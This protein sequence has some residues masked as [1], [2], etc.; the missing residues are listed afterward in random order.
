M[1]QAA[2]D[3]FQRRLIS[4]AVKIIK[5]PDVMFPARSCVRALLQPQTMEKRRGRE[6]CRR[7]T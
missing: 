7:R 3:E 6:P 1:S 2:A 5:L 4:F